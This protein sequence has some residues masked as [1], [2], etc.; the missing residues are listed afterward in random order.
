MSKVCKSCGWTTE[1]KANFCE[2]CG[3]VME[4]TLD[5]NPK[6]IRNKLIVGVAI[7]FVIALIG[8][9]L[10]QPKKIDF[11]DYL[12]GKVQGYNGSGSYQY[13]FDDERFETDI[14]NILEKKLETEEQIEEAIFEIY[15]AFSVQIDPLESVLSNGDKVTIRIKVNN[16][17]IKK[18]GIRFVEKDIT[19]NV[20]GLKEKTE[21]DV[22][23]DF[24]L[25][26]R[27]IAP[28]AEVEEEVWI[29]IGDVSVQAS[30]TPNRGLCVGD[31]VVVTIDEETVPD[32]YTL[33][34]KE[35]KFKIENID[36]YILDAKELT[37]EDLEIIKNACLAELK[38]SDALA[39]HNVY[40]QS[41]KNTGNDSSLKMEDNFKKGTNFNV[42]N[43]AYFYANEME[44]DSVNQ[45]AMR[46]EV[47]TV[48]DNEWEKDY[49]NKKFHFYSIIQVQN[50]YRKVDG[51]LRFE[52][53]ICEGNVDDG[54]DVAALFVDKADLDDAFA[55]YYNDFLASY[56]EYTLTMDGSSE[57]TLARKAVIPTY[58]DDNDDYDE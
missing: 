1:K 50:I 16:E 33:K 46:F 5:K 19:V 27:N 39:Y 54:N 37:K 13:E 51:T 57:A 14:K 35:K 30:C 40:P 38:K 31:E 34:E 9:L 3:G 53:C 6:G 47:D 49:F 12:I 58:N 29:E 55:A 42:L 4:E 43:D 18:Y 25:N 2:N 44:E 32:A 26:V 17:S 22:F 52:E 56:D 23:K 48:C 15:D 28:F 7:L 21:L 10:M 8:Y 45:M 24:S 36:H 41:I 20:E 11:E